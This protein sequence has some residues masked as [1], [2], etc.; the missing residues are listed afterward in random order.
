MR[1]TIELARTAVQDTVRVRGQASA[2]AYQGLLRIE[3]VD[4]I[5]GALIALS[6][7][8]E[9]TPDPAVRAAAA[10]LLRLLRPAL[11]VLSV[12]IRADEPGRRGKPALQRLSRLG[13]AMDAMAAAGRIPILAGVTDAILERL[14]IAATLTAP[15]NWQPGALPEAPA[16]PLWQRFTTPLRANLDWQSAAFRH[17]LRTAVVAGPAL[18]VTLSLNG[19][20]QHWLTITL[21]LTMQPFYALTWQRALERIGGTVLGSLVAAVVALL[22][23]T[24]L[25]S[26][27]RCSRWPCW[28]S[29]RGP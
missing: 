26:P 6:D 1:D 3:T 24:P 12:A 5:F 14:R 19:S 7:L 21:I 27:R 15:A 11:L 28:P 22:C 25:S 18:A 23:T 13:P 20:Y 4:Q 9:A 17:A 8:L 16:A 2:R 29:P 10:R